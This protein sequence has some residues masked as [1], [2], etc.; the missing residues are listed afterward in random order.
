M[1][2]YYTEILFGKV[3]ITNIISMT[4]DTYTIGLIDS[5]QSVSK[6]WFTDK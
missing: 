1:E 6:V 4:H 5:H 3:F 2:V